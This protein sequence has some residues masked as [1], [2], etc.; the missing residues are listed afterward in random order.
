MPT[1]TADWIVP[2]AGPP[3]RGGW[4][5]TRGG[6]VAGLGPGAPPPASDHVVACGAVAILPALVNAHTHL[7]LS[8]LRGRVPPARSFVDWVSAMM[9]VRLGA[10]DA[11]DTSAHRAAMA[12]AADEMR[13]SGTGLVGDISNS[14]AGVD[15]LA[16]ALHA[17]V[18][19]HELVG[20]RTPDP[21][22]VVDRALARTAAVRGRPGWRVALAPHAPYSV[23]PG[24]FRAIAAAQS[25]GPLAVHV[26]EG[27]DEVDLV[28]SGAGRWPELLRAMG[29]WDDTWVVPGCS[30]VEYLDRLGVWTPRTLAVHAVHA[31][32]ATS[33]PASRPCRRSSTRVSG[34]RWARTV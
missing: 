15:L 30:P 22:G 7:E 29:A 3:L 28:T 12:A 5:S 34:S 32:T 11:G 21:S 9:R 14:L 16:D 6:V 26:A 24:L 2:I 20:F 19:F 8:W 33:A 25:D 4:V 17:G 27:A 18:V 1:Y 13:A 23:S 10:P 31:S